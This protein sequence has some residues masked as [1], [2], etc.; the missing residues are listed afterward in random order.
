MPSVT[1]RNEHEPIDAMIRRFKKQVDKADTINDA[2][3]HEFYE[4]PTSNRKRAK[5]AAGK[6]EEKRRR[7]DR[8]PSKTP[9]FKKKKEKPRYNKPQ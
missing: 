5:A 7:E 3:K 9:S 2:R 8:L 1:R 6:R 4:K